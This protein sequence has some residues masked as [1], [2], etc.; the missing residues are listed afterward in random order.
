[1]T[2]DQLRSNLEEFSYRGRR[3]QSL[4]YTAVEPQGDF[5]EG[6]TIH[7][8]YLGHG[9]FSVEYNDART[10]ELHREIFDLDQAV[11]YAQDLLGALDD[12]AHDEALTAEEQQLEE[13]QAARER[14]LE[15]EWEQRHG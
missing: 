5:D 9:Y 3:G 4:T 10:T 13:R 11:Q 6:I 2:I 12:V 15:F 8:L 1:M 14:S 7:Y